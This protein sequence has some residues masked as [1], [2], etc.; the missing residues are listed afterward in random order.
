MPS[1]RDQNKTEVFEAKKT[2][3]G[4]DK[5]A[6]ETRSTTPCRYESMYLGMSPCR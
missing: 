2:F 5:E 3:F 1:I 6:I 4:S